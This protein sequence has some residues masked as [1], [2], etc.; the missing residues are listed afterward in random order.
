MFEE[1]TGVGGLRQLTTD[2]VCVCVCVCD[3]KIT[4][5]QYLFSSLLSFLHSSLPPF[6]LSLVASVI[7]LKLSLHILLNPKV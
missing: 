6:L 1:S 5:P 2:V 4:P 7:F 3:N